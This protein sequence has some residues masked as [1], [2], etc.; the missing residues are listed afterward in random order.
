MLL[1][2]CIS[3]SSWMPKLVLSFGRWGISSCH[4]F[5]SFVKIVFL[6]SLELFASGRRHRSH[7]RHSICSAML[8]A[9]KM[10]PLEIEVVQ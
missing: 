3:S 7:Q 4:Q 1:D 6:V 9:Q 5:V 8:N 10:D 2:R